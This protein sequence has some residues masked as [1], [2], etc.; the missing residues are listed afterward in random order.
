[1]GTSEKLG[2]EYDTSDAILTVNAGAGGTDAQDWAQMLLRCTSGG[3]NQKAG[4]PKY[5]M[6]QREKKPELKAQQLKS[7]AN[8]HTDTPKPK[9]E[10]T[11]GKNFTV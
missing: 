11:G 6:L 9:K 3:L 4:K 1:M 10:F 8:T 5:S 7:A 2:G